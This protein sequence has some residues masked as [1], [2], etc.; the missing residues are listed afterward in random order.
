[1]GKRVFGKGAGEKNVCRN[2]RGGSG[3][4]GRNA[5]KRHPPVSVKEKR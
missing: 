4:R 1:M 5:K 2:N 3:H